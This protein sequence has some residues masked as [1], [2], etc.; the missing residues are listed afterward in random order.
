M[1]VF[2]LALLVGIARVGDAPRTS[3]FCLLYPLAPLICAAH[4][5]YMLLAT[6]FA[7]V[8]CLVHPTQFNGAKEPHLFSRLPL[9]EFEEHF[10]AYL[11]FYARSGWA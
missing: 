7:L 9:L 2:P 4:P 6:P 8:P 10:A 1:W 11:D 5:Y 3:G